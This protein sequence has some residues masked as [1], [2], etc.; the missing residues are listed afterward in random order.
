MAFEPIV[1]ITNI[2]DK[3]AY[4]YVESQNLLDYIEVLLTPFD[5]LEQVY[6]DILNKRIFENATSSVLDVYGKLVVQSRGTYEIAEVQFFGLDASD[7][8]NPVPHEGLGDLTDPSLG[9]LFRS[10]D[11]PLIDRINLPDYAYKQTIVG[12]VHKNNFKG[13]TENLIQAINDLLFNEDT[14]FVEITENFTTP[15]DPFVSI[16]FKRPLSNIEKSYLVINDAVPKPGG[17]RYEFS[18][19]NGSF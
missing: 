16:D 9:G 2:K 12:K 3:I 6:T 1:N 8:N 18:D 11:Q 15:A 19:T 17:I 13:G 5:E 4:Q 10:L 7:P 14:G